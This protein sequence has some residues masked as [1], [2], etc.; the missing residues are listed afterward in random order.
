MKS[1]DHLK[2]GETCSPHG[3]RGEL[4]AFFHSREWISRFQEEEILKNALLTGRGKSLPSLI[5]SV[6]SFKRG[7]LIKLEGVQTRS[8]A[9]HFSGFHIQVPSSFLKSKPGELIYLYEIL[10]FTVKTKT[11]SP[12]GVIT[13]FSSNGP[14]DLLTVETLQGKKDIP[15]V[16]EFVSSLSFQ[17]RW[18]KMDLPEGLLNL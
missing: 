12:I 14:Q 7:V 18:I 16:E 5:K 17:N 3:L 10:D 6:R 15:L 1:K 8:D 4:Y 13:G 11:G 2:V 9:A